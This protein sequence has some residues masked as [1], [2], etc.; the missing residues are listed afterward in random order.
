MMVPISSFSLFSVSP[1]LGSV[2]PSDSRSVVLSLEAEDRCSI[3]LF[4]LVLCESFLFS[5]NTLSPSF[6]LSPNH[7]YRSIRIP[8]PQLVLK[9][10]QEPRFGL[11]QTDLVHVWNCIWK[12]GLLSGTDPQGEDVRNISH[13][14]PF[15][16]GTATP[17]QEGRI[18]K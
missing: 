10:K 16:V 8:S 12:T 9:E 17:L 6:T 11:Q 7:L 2:Y 18:H 15:R 13:Q 1:F 4:H 3:A 5:P 14:R